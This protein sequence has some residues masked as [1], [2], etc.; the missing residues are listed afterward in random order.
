VHCNAVSNKNGRQFA[1]IMDGVIKIFGDFLSLQR[2]TT[3]K[4]FV[5]V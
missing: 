3:R 4:R 5:L 1:S 2:I